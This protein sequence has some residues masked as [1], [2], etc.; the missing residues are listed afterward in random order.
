MVLQPQA[1]LIFL[2]LNRTTVTTAALERALKGF[3]SGSVGLS[4][5]HPR[6]TTIW[7]FLGAT[8]GATLDAVVARE[9]SKGGECHSSSAEPADSP[10]DLLASMEVARLLIGAATM[11]RMLTRVGHRAVLPSRWTDVLKNVSSNCTIDWE[12]FTGKKFSPVA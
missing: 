8:K 3:G 4:G 2:A 10:H 5:R 6:V 11:T 9:E 1:G 12:V 7:P